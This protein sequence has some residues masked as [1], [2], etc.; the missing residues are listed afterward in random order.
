MIKKNGKEKNI[1]KRVNMKKNLKK[2]KE[3]EKEFFIFFNSDKYEGDFKNYK[4]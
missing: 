4:I 1:I 2:V 3:K